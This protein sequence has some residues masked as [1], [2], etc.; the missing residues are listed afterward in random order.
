MQA[1][2]LLRCAICDTTISDAHSTLLAP[3]GRLAHLTCVERAQ[4]EFSTHRAVVSA[5]DQDRLTDLTAL[6]ADLEREVAELRRTNFPIERLSIYLD[7]RIVTFEQ[8]Y[9]RAPPATMHQAIARFRADLLGEIKDQ[10]K[11]MSPPKE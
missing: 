10:I 5:N 4:I 11:A 2:P 6:L 3:S 8:D 9:L 7:D 1:P